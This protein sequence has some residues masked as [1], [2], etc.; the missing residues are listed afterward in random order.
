MATALST[1]AAAHSTAGKI[2]ADVADRL[3]SASSGMTS[4]PK[5]IPSGC[6]VWRTP[7]ARPRC[8]GGNHPDTSLPPAELQLA[9]A[10]P[11]TNSHAANATIEWAVVAA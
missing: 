10:M 11:P 7:I 9:A 6:A 5:A 4:A 3:R 1:A 8:S 2:S